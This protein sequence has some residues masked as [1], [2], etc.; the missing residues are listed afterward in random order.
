[1]KE[2]LVKLISTKGLTASKF[3]DEIGVQRSGISHI[4]SG[5]NQPSYDFIVK[6]M[7]KFTDLNI[8][9]LLTG[10]GPMYKQ[11]IIQKDITDVSS[12][13][14]NKQ[15]DLFSEQLNSENKH[16]EIIKNNSKVTNVNLV[17]NV[18]LLFDNGTFKLFEQGRQD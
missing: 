17:K 8:E 13:M 2:R 1:M 6:V 15:F 5:R 9:W 14:K 4:I 7:E 16:K 12:D 11:Q 18:V 10:N 3:A